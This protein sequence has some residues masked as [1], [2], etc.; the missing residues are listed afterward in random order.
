MGCSGANYIQ[1]DAQQPVYFGSPPKGIVLLDSAHIKFIRPLVATTSHIAEKEK[2]TTVKHI[3]ITTGGL[4]ETES[5]IE[6][7]VAKAFEEDPDRFISDI[8]IRA[9]VE[10]YIPWDTVVFDLIGLMFS[11]EAIAA[12]GADAS[13]E[14]ITITGKVYRQWGDKR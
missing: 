1:V 14:T 7:E 11:Q 4:E 5:S 10:A 12:G 6:L 3:D 2:T 9:R 8:S 13:S